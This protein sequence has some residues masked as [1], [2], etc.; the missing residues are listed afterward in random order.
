MSVR[1]LV[2][3]SWLVDGRVVDW[4][5]LDVDPVMGGL[6]IID[7]LVSHGEGLENLGDFM[8]QRQRKEKKKHTST[9]LM[10][11][12]VQELRRAS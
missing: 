11:L 6:I 10:I 9:G 1:W 12:T 2:C 3:L 7:K 8:L 5:L 4:L